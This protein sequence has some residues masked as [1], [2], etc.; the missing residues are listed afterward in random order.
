MQMQS[1]VYLKNTVI[2]AQ[3][4]NELQRCMFQKSLLSSLKTHQNVVSNF[5]SF[6][7]LLDM[8][9]QYIKHKTQCFIGISK[10]WDIQTLGYPNTDKRKTHSR[11]LLTKF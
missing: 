5:G 9:M 6:S 10:H 3:Y 1:N 11:V 4:E 2:F 8:Y 7:D